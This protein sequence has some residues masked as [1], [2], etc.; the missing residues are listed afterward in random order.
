MES[1][2]DEALGEYKHLVYC[3]HCEIEP[4]IDQISDCTNAHPWHLPCGVELVELPEG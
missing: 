3:P 1:I 2:R 4:D